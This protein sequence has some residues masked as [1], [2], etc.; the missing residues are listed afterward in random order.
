M[1]AVQVV[2]LVAVRA[3]RVRAVEPPAVLPL[4]P[5][6]ADAKAPLA[7]P[8]PRAVQRTRPRPRHVVHPHVP[9]DPAQT[10]V[11]RPPE[12][13]QV[14]AVDRSRV[15]AAPHGVRVVARVPQLADR[16]ARHVVDPQ[17]PE[18]ALRVRG[19][20]RIALCARAPAEEQ[21]LPAAPGRR[22]GVTG[23]HRHR[24]HALAHAH[25][26]SSAPQTHRNKQCA[27]W[28]ERAEE[29]ADLVEGV[30]DDGAGARHDL[31]VVPDAADRGVERAVPVPPPRA[32]PEVLAHDAHERLDLGPRHRLLEVFGLR[33]QHR[34]E[35]VEEERI[36][37]DGASEEQRR[38]GAHHREAPA[39]APE[40]EVAQGA[41]PRP[42]LHALDVLPVVDGRVPPD[43]D[44]R[45]REVVGAG[46]LD[47]H[48]LGLAVEPERDAVLDVH[49]VRLVHQRV[50]QQV[51]QPV[52]EERHRRQQHVEVR[53]PLR[54]R[55]DAVE[56]RHVRDQVRARQ[57]DLPPGLRVG[58][59][60]RH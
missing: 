6:V 52:R 21:Q 9:A 41:Q 22:V 44:L 20:A 7:R 29:S 3:Q 15:V 40:R 39:V 54:V 47:A 28:Q 19:V 34:P 10:L 35:V 43:L 5:P 32:P 12:E 51:L 23:V 60:Q 13:V 31:E 24:Q 14:V 16:V 58:V 33:Q 48:V 59:G 49:Q 55:V 46:Q 30:E 45:E 2:V 8:V 1:Q 18:V 37:L 25:S 27:R 26:R 17:V 53:Q 4:E 36:L 57:V 11:A 56:D 42:T 50:L 38:V